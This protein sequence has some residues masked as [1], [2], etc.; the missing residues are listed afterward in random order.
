MMSERE[1][2]TEQ[3]TD[4]YRVNRPG[5][6]IQGTGLG[7]HITKEIVRMHGGIIKVQSKLN[8]GTKFKIYMPLTKTAMTC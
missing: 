2:A 3:V 8:Q 5:T 1:T 6:Q 4:P 7:L